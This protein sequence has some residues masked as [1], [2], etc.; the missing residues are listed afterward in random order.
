MSFDHFGLNAEILR[1]IAEQGYESPTE[2]QNQAIEI[3]LDGDDMLAGSQTGTGKTAAFALPIIENLSADA[4]RLKRKGR[5]PRALILTPTRELAAQVCESFR[6]YGK[7]LPLQSIEIFGGVS[8]IPQKEKLRRGV[9][10]LVATPGRL[11]DH[12]SQ[13]R[14][15]LSE[16]EI[17]VLDEA[18]R[19]LD[20]GFIHDIKK[21]LTTLPKARQ[22]LMFSATYSQDIKKLA[23]TFL[24]NPVFVEVTKGNSA[25]ATVAQ[26]VYKVEKSHKRHLLR[27]LIEDGAW[28]QVL[29][30][31]RTKHGANRLAQQLSTSKIET[32]AIHGNKSQGARTA[33]LANF[34]SGK[35]RVLVA[36]DIAARGIDIEELPHVV[37]YDLPNVPEDYVH[38]IG[39][40]GR[41]GV[42]G[43][44]ISLVDGSEA[45]FLRDIEKLLGS[46]LPVG[47]AEDFEVPA[48][49]P[50]ANQSRKPNKGSD[51]QRQPNGQR[52]NQKARQSRAKKENSPQRDRAA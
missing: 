4:A 1:A 47:E 27:H 50:N 2:I 48:P 7:F 46:K 3:I 40:T 26:L 28:H 36:T 13:N 19:M 20:M 25:A 12:L 16:I 35:V 42:N 9:D 41:A 23:Q 8:I 44:A 11:L 29:V 43:I 33:A 30:F 31:T 51:K 34:K 14:G 45:K 39:R 37:N 52:P 5:K 38:R 10:V 15:L 24:R 49:N 32:A 18:D 17:F 21:V 6:T 22:N